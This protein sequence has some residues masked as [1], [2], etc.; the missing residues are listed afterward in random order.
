MEIPS[1]HTYATCTNIPTKIQDTVIIHEEQK[2]R[3]NDLTLI[4]L[5]SELQLH[6][7]HCKPNT[8]ISIHSYGANKISEI[9]CIRQENGSTKSQDK[10][11]KCFW[12]FDR[13]TIR[14]TIKIDKNIPFVHK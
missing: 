6:N 8:E 4:F 9:N 1:V 3:E 5:M 7:F 13:P 14:P 2:K 11:S 10:I 12:V